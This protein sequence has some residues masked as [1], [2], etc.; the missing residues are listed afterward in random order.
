[1]WVNEITLGQI[2]LGEKNPAI[3]C[4]E[5]THKLIKVEIKE[6]AKRHQ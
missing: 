2:R 6:M 1:M 5:V 4:L 3:C